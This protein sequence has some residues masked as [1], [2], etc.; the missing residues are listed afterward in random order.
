MEHWAKMRYS[1]LSQK[2]KNHIEKLRNYLNK[3]QCLEK[4]HLC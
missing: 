2:K 1:D 3:I 4:Y